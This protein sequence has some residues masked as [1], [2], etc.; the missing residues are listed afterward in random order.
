MLY[1]LVRARDLSLDLIIISVHLCNHV[2]VLFSHIYSPN[3]EASMLSGIVFFSFR[4]CSVSLL[5][6]PPTYLDEYKPLN[7]RVSILSSD[8]EFPFESKISDSMLDG[9]FQ[10]HC[11]NYR[12]FVRRLV[13]ESILSPCSNK[14]VFPSQ[15]VSVFCSNFLDLSLSWTLLLHVANAFICPKFMENKSL[16]SAIHGYSL[17]NSDAYIGDIF[18]RQLLVSS[19]KFGQI[20]GPIKDSIASSSIAPLDFTIN[21]N[22]VDIAF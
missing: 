6:A 9:M 16:L 20:Y 5:M 10:F 12:R 14:I 21:R 22:V 7:L 4:N 3:A 18:P 13:G 19:D 11:A 17:W 1:L 15:T 2:W 8:L